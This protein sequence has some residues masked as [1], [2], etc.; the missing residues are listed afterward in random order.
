M[1]KGF[2]AYLCF[3]CTWPASLQLAARALVYQR[4]RARMAHVAV[5][6]DDGSVRL[7]D[8]EGVLAVYWSG[9]CDVSRSV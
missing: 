4:V 3:R 2:L 1:R 6:D 8:L 9:H 7:D 5:P